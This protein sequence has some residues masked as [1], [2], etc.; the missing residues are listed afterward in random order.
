VALLHYPVV[1]K[2]GKIIASAITNLDIHD[3]ARAVKT[4]GAK[5]FYVITPL[6][7]QKRIAERIMSHWT[8][9]GGAEY[10]PKRRK[11][12]ES[13]RISDSLD[14]A[15]EDISNSEGIR[16]KT[17]ATHAG[18]LDCCMGYAEFKGII[19][20]GLPHL[21]I[22]GT[23]W[24]LSPEIIKSADYLLAPVQGN[25]DYNHLSVRSAVSIIL[26]RLLG[27]RD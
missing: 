18:S 8:E 1:N 15:I 10:N 12:L 9:R 25:T 11:A 13:I 4:F 26:D 24:G 22:F 3:I 5:A 16:P 21:L 14:Q 2:E 20:K 6:E 7:D 17:V 19:Q 27:I 23:G